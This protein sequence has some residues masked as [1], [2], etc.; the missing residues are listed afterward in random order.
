VAGLL[1][2]ARE[3]GR[4]EGLYAR[5]RVEA[6]S[7]HLRGLQE[8]QHG[9]GA[10]AT[11]GGADDQWKMAVRPPTS[12]QRP[13]GTGLSSLRASLALD[14]QWRQRQP[15]TAGSSSAS[16]CARG[17]GTARP[18]WWVRGATSRAG[19]PNSKTVRLNLL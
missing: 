1:G 9:P 4:G 8:L 19:S 15:R 3:R 12:A 10:V 14:A 2:H 6:V 13:R 17:L 7:P 5:W 18:T 11:C 16:A